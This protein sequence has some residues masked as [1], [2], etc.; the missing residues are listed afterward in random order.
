MDRC[1]AP[2]A[3]V[4]EAQAAPA[5]PAEDPAERLT[6]RLSAGRAASRAPWRPTPELGSPWRLRGYYFLFL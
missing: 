4:A 6:M 2:V 3:P 1:L 5:A